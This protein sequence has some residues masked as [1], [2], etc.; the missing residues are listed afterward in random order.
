[1]GKGRLCKKE[2]VEK[3]FSPLEAFHKKNERCHIVEKSY[4]VENNILVLKIEDLVR[5]PV[6]SKFI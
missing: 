6:L 4:D 1:L 3:L 2:S 5:K